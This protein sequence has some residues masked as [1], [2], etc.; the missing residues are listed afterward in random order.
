MVGEEEQEVRLCGTT[1]IGET[2]DYNPRPAVR[3]RHLAGAATMSD[4]SRH[5]EEGQEGEEVMETKD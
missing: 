2:L 1:P 5:S 3:L 4:Q